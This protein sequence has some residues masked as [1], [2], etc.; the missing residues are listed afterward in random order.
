MDTDRFTSFIS[1]QL[2]T[3]Y[4][5]DLRSRVV[6]SNLFDGLGGLAENRWEVIEKICDRIASTRPDNLTD[7]ES[8]VSS[9]AFAGVLRPY[10]RVGVRWLLGA[11]ENSFGCILGDESKLGK[12]VQVMAF[13]AYLEEH[14]RTS[15][16]HL[17]VTDDVSSWRFALER[18]LPHTVVMEFGKEE[19]S[20]CS[21]NICLVDRETFFSDT[22]VN[23]FFQVQIIDNVS[24]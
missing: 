7:T 17:I 22:F 4:V 20:L 16:P 12:K 21:H 14:R 9:M 8:S 3:D 11:Y 2:P 23:S 15:G 6:I 18:F 10:Q 19:N 1:F 24:E 5:E 13:L